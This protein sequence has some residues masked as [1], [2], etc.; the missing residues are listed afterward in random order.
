MKKKLLIRVDAN[1][2]IGIGHVTRCLHFANNFKN[3]EIYFF[4]KKNTRIKEFISSYNYRVIELQ[5]DFS[6]NE[7]L[8]I[9]T[10]YSSNLLILDIRGEKDD[11][12]KDFSE[13]F[14]KILR[15]D[16]SI[17]SINI[18]SDFYLNYNLYSEN[19][20][21]SAVNEKCNLFLGPKYYVI[22][23]IFT[24]YENYKKL[25]RDHVENILITMGGSDPK[26]L[27][28]KIIETIVN[29]PNIHLNVV[30]GKLYTNFDKI[31]LLKKGFDSKITLFHDIHDMPEK[32]TNNDLIITSG[33]NTSF[34]AAFMGIPGTLINQNELQL[35]N[36]IMYDKKGTF[37]D[38]GM[39]EKLLKEVI[40]ERI[41]KLLLSKDLRYK[42][43]HKCKELEIS[44]DIGTVIKKFIS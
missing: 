16:D 27:T 7:E 43:Y 3:Y 33:G 25:I 29:L 17:N 6:K 37:L 9:L 38:L 12:Y 44:Q 24:K 36:S 19:I 1:S 20:K 13:K 41:K 4:I 42:M 5:N 11:Y 2:L 35:K 34:E 26:N 10:S 21:F 15:F 40:R 18:Y 23:P 22:N 28:L 39:G 30:L 32:M 8:E 14:K 31:N